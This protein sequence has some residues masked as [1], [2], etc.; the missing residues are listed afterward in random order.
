MGYGFG[1]SDYY[2]VRYPAKG[3]Y[4]DTAGRVRT[5]QVD[6]PATTFI[7]GESRMIRDQPSIYGAEYVPTQFRYTNHG[8]DWHN[9]GGD[10]LWGDGH[11]TRMLAEVLNEDHFD[12]RK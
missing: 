4:G 8:G 1:S 5:Y 12:R 9:G 6:K 7:I 10:Y 11:A 3:S 2:R